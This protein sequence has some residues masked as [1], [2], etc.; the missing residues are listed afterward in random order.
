LHDAIER[1]VVITDL[2]HGLSGSHA[3][4]PEDERPA[5]LPT[6]YL[7]LATDF[8]VPNA[9]HLLLVRQRVV[10]V[11]QAHQPFFQHMGVNLRGRNI[12]VAEKLLH[13]AQIG[14]IL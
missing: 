10:V 1:D 11:D 9:E 14:A 2:A 5:R 6:T 4:Y 13:G 7:V 12:G 3:F 8:A